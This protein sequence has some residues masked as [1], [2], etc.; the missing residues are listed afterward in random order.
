VRLQ[1]WKGTLLEFVDRWSGT[2]LGLSCLYLGG[3]LLGAL[4]VAALTQQDQVELK[5][6]MLT[7]TDLALSGVSGGALFWRSLASNLQILLF[8]W[9]AGLSLI[10]IV[11]IW[12][13]A[14]LRG[15]I[16]GFTLAFMAAQFG[17]PGL[18]MALVGMLPGLLFHVPGLILGG[19]AGVAFGLSM[20]RA[21]RERR[22]PA[23]LYPVI[24]AYTISLLLLGSGLPFASLVDGFLA[25]RLVARV[26]AHQPLISVN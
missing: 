6:Y 15:F 17:V 1:A 26:L 21:W 16:T 4:A 11:G 13:L 8:I 3:V 23:A 12:G 10:G 22:R 19:T 9:L 7:V 24:A 14:V 18:W 5:R 2:I 20:I 25:P